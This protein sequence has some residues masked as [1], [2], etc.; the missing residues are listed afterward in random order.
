MKAMTFTALGFALA[1]PVSAQNATPSIGLPALP[2]PTE[3]KIDARFTWSVTD[4]AN[5]P[6]GEAGAL[7]LREA[8]IVITANA[9]GLF[10]RLGGRCL[11]MMRT[12]AGDDYAASGGCLLADADGDRIFEHFEEAAGRGHAVITGGTGKFA[13]LSGEYELDTTAWYTAVREGTDQG[14]GTKIGVWRKS[15]S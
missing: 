12:G 14:V 15:G 11:M 9:P 2:A 13:G 6:A 10:D 4:L 7:R 3:G 8:H 5:L 1:L